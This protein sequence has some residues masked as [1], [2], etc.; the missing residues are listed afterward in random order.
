MNAAP[1]EVLRVPCCGKTFLRDQLHRRRTRDVYSSGIWLPQLVQVS[2]ETHM[3][4]YMQDLPLVRLWTYRPRVWLLCL[5]CQDIRLTDLVAFQT[6]DDDGVKTS[7]FM[8][9]KR[10]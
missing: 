10:A 6:N 7:R 2:Y 5:F 8:N 1:A 9:N 4:M 3:T